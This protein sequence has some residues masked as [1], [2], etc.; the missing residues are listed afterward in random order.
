MA[1]QI[2]K[3]VQALRLIFQADDYAGN[4]SNFSV[5]ERPQKSAGEW[6]ELRRFDNKLITAL[7]KLIPAILLRMK[8]GSAEE[9]NSVNLLQFSLEHHHPLIKRV[10]RRNGFGGSFQ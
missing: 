4:F 3:P 6:A 5:Q 2:I 1:L 9:K 8:N 10:I 7:D